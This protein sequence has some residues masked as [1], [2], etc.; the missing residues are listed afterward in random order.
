MLCGPLI[1]VVTVC[2]SLL[3]PEALVV[4]LIIDLSLGGEIIGWQLG[5]IWI[6]SSECSPATVLTPDVLSLCINRAIPGR[7]DIM[8][9]IHFTAMTEY[10]RLHNFKK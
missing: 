8:V 9:L 5:L 4:C 6:Q 2:V 1:R 3:L 7:N 10:L